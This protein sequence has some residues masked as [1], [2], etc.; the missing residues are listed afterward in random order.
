MTLKDFIKAIPLEVCPTS[1]ILLKVCKTL[2]DHPLP[3]L[4]EAELYVTVNSDDP[5]MFDTTLTDELS[6]CAETFNW[7]ESQIE[8]LTLNALGAAFYPER[9][10]LIEGYRAAFKQLREQIPVI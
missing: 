3:K 9:Q 8:Q 10:T 5:P 7:D 4:I 1:N 2:A 6:R